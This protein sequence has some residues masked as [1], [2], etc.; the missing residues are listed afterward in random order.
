VFFHDELAGAA[1]VVDAAEQDRCSDGR[2]AG[3]RQLARGREDAQPRAVR[4][5]LRWQHKDSLRVVEFARDRLHGGGVEPVGIEHDRKRIAGKA[6]IGENVERCETA[7]HRRS[8]T[9]R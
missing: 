6:P 9:R 4:T 8:L 7:L 5:I 1:A 2:M 3:E